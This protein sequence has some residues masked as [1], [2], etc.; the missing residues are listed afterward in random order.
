MSEADIGRADKRSRLEADPAH[1]SIPP[2]GECDKD[3]ALTTV[4]ECEREAAATMTE[5]SD[6]Q[7]EREA[8]DDSVD[9][10]EDVH[11]IPDEAQA[12]IDFSNNMTV[13][14]QRHV[15]KQWR[16]Q[17]LHVVLLPAMRDS[18]PDNALLDINVI[19][20]VA[21]YLEDSERARMTFLPMVEKPEEG[22]IFPITVSKFGGQC[23]CT[24]C[25]CCLACWR[26][27]HRCLAATDCLMSP[28]AVLTCCPTRN[29]RCV[30][31]AACH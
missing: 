25:H 29:G 3:A 11:A 10:D 21:D 5:K 1:A 30:V 27:F 31:R 23:C 19:E 14:A 4:S 26:R 13:P 22:E 18:L 9:E 15:Q 28:S 12:F 8:D 2:P 7:R 24:T 16:M 20:L 17:C 6:N